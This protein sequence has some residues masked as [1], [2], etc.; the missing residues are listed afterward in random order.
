[1]N[2]NSWVRKGNLSWLEVEREYYQERGKEPEMREMLLS[3]N[4]Y[5]RV[6]CSE[7]V[8]WILARHVRRR[9]AEGAGAKDAMFVEADVR[10]K[11]MSLRREENLLLDQV[12]GRGMHI[13]IKGRGRPHNKGRDRARSDILRGT[14]IYNFHYVAE[15]TLPQIALM[16]GLDR[17]YTYAIYYVDWNNQEILQYM[18]QRISTWHSEVLRL[19]KKGDTS[20]AEAEDRPG[21][22]N[23]LLLYGK[24]KQG[25]FLELKSPYGVEGS[26][27]E[28]S[29]K[30]RWSK[31]GGEK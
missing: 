21:S 28:I 11:P 18:K 27:N 13:A 26:V 20:I 6:V 5:R 24:A 23:G 29:E 15:M 2:I 8:E 10:M 31:N 9:R 1:L 22:R 30:D 12:M 14:A 19:V 4:Q 17:V 7:A 16:A 25:G 3:A